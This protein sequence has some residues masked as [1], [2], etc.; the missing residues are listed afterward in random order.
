M[1][2]LFM[3]AFLVLS[4]TSCSKDTLDP[5]LEE[6]YSI[7]KSEIL[8]TVTNMVYNQ[9]QCGNGCGSGEQSIAY[10]PNANVNI[11]LGDVKDGDSAAVPCAQGRTDSTGKWLMKDLEPGKYTVSVHSVYGNK[12]R[13]LYTQLNHRASIEFSF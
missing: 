5:G 6:N 1:K 12:F 10:V 4:I 7:Q 11:Y 2:N 3:L 8:V 13:V 9:G